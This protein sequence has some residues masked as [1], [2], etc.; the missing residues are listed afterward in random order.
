MVCGLIGSECRLHVSIGF[1]DYPSKDYDAHW[2]IA[3]LD[4][5]LP[6]L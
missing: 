6:D 1:F 2:H 4:N 3:S 5:T